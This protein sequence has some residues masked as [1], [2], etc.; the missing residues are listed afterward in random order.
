LNADFKSQINIAFRAR[1]T[2]IVVMTI[3]ED[4]AIQLIK[5]VCETA[6][7]PRQ[8]VSWDISDGFALLSGRNSPPQAKDPLQALDA[9]EKTE[10]GAVIIL[11]DFHEFWNNSQVKRKIRNYAQKFKFS[12]RSMVIITPTLQ[13]PDELRDDAITMHFLP[14]SAEELLKEL[15]MLIQGSNVPCTLSKLGKEKIIQA[16]LGMTLNQARR[17]FSKAIVSH[18][19][20]DDRNIEEVIAEKKDILSQSQ[21][22]EFYGGT[23]TIDNVGGL[24]VLKRWLLLREKAF[25]HEAREYGLPAPKGIALIGIPGTGKSLTAKMIAGL[26]KLPLLRLDVGS[27]FGSLVGESEE[28][29]RRAL[30]LA[31]TIAPC[32]LWIDEIEKAFSFG[33]GDSGTSQRVFASLLTWMQDKSAPCF[34]VATANN[35]AALP[36][37]LLRKGRFDEI[38]FLD[39][40]NRDERREIFSVHLKKRNWIPAE[41]DIDLLVQVSEGYV[42]AEIEQTVI[43]AMYLA[44]NEGL[45]KIT[46]E[47]IVSCLKQQVPLSRSQRETVEMLRRWLNEGRALSASE[48]EATDVKSPGNILLE[49]Y[50]LH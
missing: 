22:L 24:S 25:T 14:P 27:L 15:E 8:C 5:G 33:S 19:G 37:E 39:L 36:P 23:E 28:R 34:V 48:G 1:I 17:S 43:D 40:P 6:Y 16:A 10:D 46:T 38:F 11:K 13:I 7:P 45:R 2:L 3:E 31:E 42:G 26:W 20:L 21:G 30:T 12:R 9:M 32:I 29:T 4:R 50:P 41:F 47:D 18:G 44:F 49:P 35:I